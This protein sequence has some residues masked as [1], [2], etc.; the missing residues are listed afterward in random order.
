MASE[1]FLYQNVGDFN[2]TFEFK[3]MVYLPPTNLHDGWGEI[4]R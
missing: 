2:D 1:K 3:G 4:N